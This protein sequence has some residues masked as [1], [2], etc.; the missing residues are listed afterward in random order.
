[1][2]LGILRTFQLGLRG[3]ARHGL[4]SLLTCL[5]VLFGVASVIAMLAIG[6]GLSHD[7]QSRIQ[8]LGSNNILVRSQ[9]PPESTSASA[10][11]SRL[12]VYGITTTTPS[13]SSG[14]CRTPRSSCP[15]ARS[16]STRATADRRCEARVMGTVPWFG[17]TNRFYLSDGR[18]LSD[19]D[20][21]ARAPVCVLGATVAETLF[22]LTEPV[23]KLVKLGPQTFRVVGVME[24]RT[25][26]T[27]DQQG[28]LED[29][30]S[31][32]Y[33]PI[34][35]VRQ[36]WGEVVVKISSGSRDMERVELHQ[37]QVRVAELTL[38]EPTANVLKEM[39]EHA[40]AKRDYEVVVPSRC[41]ARRSGR[42]G[43][44]TSCSGRSPASRCWSAASASPTSCWRPS[45]S[46]RA[47]SASAA[48]SAPSAATSSR[49]SWSRRS[50]WPAPAA[51]SASASG[52]AFRS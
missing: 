32:V 51:S 4:R 50:C 3:V 42:S 8:A 25:V 21:E 19:L 39:L 52:S 14:R 18:F 24:P 29:L 9:K 15:R 22:P 5:G 37:L 1:V 40:H 45:R 6:E 17:T 36:C 47:R 26:L 10:E 28:T 27:G 12:S 46:G 41:C 16:T 48:R 13:G 2:I 44:S 34:T 38:V 7:V 33:A 49:S 35:A 30:S 31:D 43:C 23:G 11:R 20:L